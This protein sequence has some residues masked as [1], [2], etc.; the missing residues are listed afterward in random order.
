M[1][2]KTI[3]IWVVVMAIL[4]PT[5]VGLYKWRDLRRA[6]WEAAWAEEASGLGLSWSVAGEG[7]S[8]LDFPARLALVGSYRGRGVEVSQHHY[9]G[10]TE[11]DPGTW[12]TLVDVRLSKAPSAEQA[13]PVLK[14]LKRKAYRPA[15]V[16]RKTLTVQRKGKHRKRGQL[17]SFL[18]EVMDAAD[19]LEAL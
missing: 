11:G 17:T 5:I 10:N 19:T 12:V 9:S 13:K 16:S 3:L 4:I 7:R 15:A 14:S 8:E 1:S 18:D 2:G 6:R